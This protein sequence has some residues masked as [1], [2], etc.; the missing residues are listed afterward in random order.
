MFY[1]QI[2]MIVKI[3]IDVRIVII[4]NT[5]MELVMKAI[6]NINMKIYNVLH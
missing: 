2:V 3:V 6:K 5:V 1:V 4:V